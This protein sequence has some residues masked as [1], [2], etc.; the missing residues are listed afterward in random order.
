MIKIKIKIE[1]IFKIKTKKIITKAVE[2]KNITSKN[3]SQDRRL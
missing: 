3:D 1:I 2:E